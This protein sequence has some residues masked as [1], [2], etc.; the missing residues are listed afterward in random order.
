MKCADSAAKTANIFINPELCFSHSAAS[1]ARVKP[2]LLRKIQ[3][4]KS[5][6][7]YRDY[8]SRAF[9]QKNGFACA[10]VILS[11]LVV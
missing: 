6:T 10:T 5:L 3:D 7:A 2:D 11:S 4:F 9:G 8:R 1:S